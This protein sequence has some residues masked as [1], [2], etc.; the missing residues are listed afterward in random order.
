MTAAIRYFGV[1]P[2]VDA[3]DAV[4]IPSRLPG[5]VERLRRRE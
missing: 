2:G 1:P 3:N 5:A 4:T